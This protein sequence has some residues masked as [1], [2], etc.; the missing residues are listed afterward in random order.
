MKKVNKIFWVW[1]VDGKIFVW[2]IEDFRLVRISE[3]W[4][5]DELVI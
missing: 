2:K 3:I 1:I 4:V 5:L